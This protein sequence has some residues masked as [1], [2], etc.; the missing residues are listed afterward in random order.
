M[1]RS[2]NRE[3]ELLR[4]FGKWIAATRKHEGITQQQLAEATDLSVVAIAY[5]ENGKRWPRLATLDKIAKV[6]NCSIH[7][8]FYALK[9]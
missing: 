2:S 3:K 4:E 5:I 7:D 9:K 8:L 1:L 6:L